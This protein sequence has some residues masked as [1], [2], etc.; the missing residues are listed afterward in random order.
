M[1]PPL[2]RAARAADAP[3]FT[4]VI[5][6]A[7]GPWI[8]RLDGLPDVDSGV[9]DEIETHPVWVAEADDTGRILGGLVMHIGTDAAQVANLAV[10]PDCGGR[11]VGRAL[12]AVAEDYARR[13][14]FTRMTL[15]SH[16]DMTPTLRFY[17]NSGWTETG[18]EG[19]RVFMEKSLV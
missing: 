16:R 19:Y 2:I 1:E 9:A 14:G 8:E 17:F 7:Y 6:A 5:R 11:G 10:H 18:R 3:A 12:M 4:D 15:A 13:A